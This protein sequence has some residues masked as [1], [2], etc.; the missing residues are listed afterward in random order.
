MA[1]RL[2]ISRRTADFNAFFADC[3]CWMSAGR[4]RGRTADS[5]GFV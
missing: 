3:P 2:L 4:Q 5:A 1:R